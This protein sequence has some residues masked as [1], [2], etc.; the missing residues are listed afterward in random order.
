LAD[1]VCAVRIG[2]GIIDKIGAAIAVHCVLETDDR[3]GRRIGI[4][5]E[6]GFLSDRVPLFREKGLLENSTAIGD[7]VPIDV[8]RAAWIRQSKTGVGV[9]AQARVCQK[10]RAVCE[11]NTATAR[12]VNDV[13]RIGVLSDVG[14]PGGVPFVSEAGY[15]SVAAGVIVPLVVA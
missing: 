8:F 5:L 13:V 7:C 15:G 14:Q 1:Q 6:P 12:K 10:V 4:I 3:R 2:G 9:A 11:R